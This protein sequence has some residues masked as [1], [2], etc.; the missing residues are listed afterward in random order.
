[1]NQLAEEVEDL[2]FLSNGSTEKQGERER[3]KERC[4]DFAEVQLSSLIS[5]PLSLEFVSVKGEE[6]EGKG[7][8]C[9]R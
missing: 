3:T 7:G 5:I 2:D 4:S 6:E 8:L 9:V 1:M